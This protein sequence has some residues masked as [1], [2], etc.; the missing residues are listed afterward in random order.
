MLRVS[1]LS[2]PMMLLALT[3]AVFGHTH[4]AV[5]Q[6][7][8]IPPITTNNKNTLLKKHRPQLK[9]NASSFWPGWPV[10]HAF[11]ENP[12]TSWFSA[13]GDGAALGQKPWVEFTF[14]EDVAI[15][16]VTVLGNRDPA[17]LK[18][19][20][21]LGGQL[22]IFDK[23]GKKLYSNTNDGIGPAA[24]FDFRMTRVLS[25]ARVIRFTALG[26]QGKENG[27]DDIAIGE[28]QVE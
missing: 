12:Q 3:G 28:I 6:V 19:F 5:A 14:P 21:I 23:N 1:R 24:D 17:W 20:T 10:E 26:D 22:E 2:L 15:K 27:Y 11:D 9:L 16:R 8:E 25:G 7:Q 18:G 4:S 13:R